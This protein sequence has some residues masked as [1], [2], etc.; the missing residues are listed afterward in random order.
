MR[1]RANRMMQAAFSS[2]SFT[3]TSSASSISFTSLLLFVLLTLSSCSRTVSSEPGVVNFLIESMPTNLDPRIGSDGQS[4]RID[5][6]MFDGL[7]EFDAQ[8][9]PRGD[10]AE[11][12]ETPDSLTYVFHLRPGE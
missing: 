8:R 12:W 6:L 10:L 4:E 11:K 9:I 7:V 2:T 3:S 1:A 5:S